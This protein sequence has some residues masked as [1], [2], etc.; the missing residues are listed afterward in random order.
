MCVLRRVHWA[1]THPKIRG[2]RRNVLAPGLLLNVTKLSKIEA[3]TKP[4]P[5]M[6]FG[7]VIEEGYWVKVW[8]NNL[9][10]TIYWTVYLSCQNLTLGK[11][12]LDCDLPLRCVL[13]MPLS[14]HKDCKEMPVQKSDLLVQ[15]TQHDG[16][17]RWDLRQV[18]VIAALAN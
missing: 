6:A 1:Q 2:L 9:D 15:S 11:T 18:N 12:S 5:F 3:L 4:N 10:T 8:T 14:S 17:T 13:I 16:A 7:S